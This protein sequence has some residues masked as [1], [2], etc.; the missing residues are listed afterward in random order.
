ME[1]Y[2]TT[3]NG[4]WGGPYAFFVD[5]LKSRWNDSG[6]CLTGVTWV[7][8]PFGWSPGQLSPLCVEFQSVGNSDVTGSFWVSG[9]QDM[10]QR[11]MANALSL[12]GGRRAKCWCVGWSISV[13]MLCD[14]IAPRKRTVLALISVTL[15]G[16]GETDPPIRIWWEF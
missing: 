3:D 9:E 11:G 7:T 4:I 10:G 14:L 12:G 5:R 6:Y 8:K 13:S 1:N 15:C 2:Q 16:L